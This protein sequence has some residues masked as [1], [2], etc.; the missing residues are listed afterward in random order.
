[1]FFNIAKLSIRGEF[2]Y[3]VV[4]KLIKRLSVEFGV[5]IGLER[6]HYLGNSANPFT[7]EVESNGTAL[8]SDC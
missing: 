4:Q 5:C 1:M 3:F 2:G 7:M 8:L 6:L